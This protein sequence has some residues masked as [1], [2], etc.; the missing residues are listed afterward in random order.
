MSN[1]TFVMKMLGRG[2]LRPRALL[3]LLTVGWAYRRRDWMKRWPFL[4][5]PPADYIAWRLHTAFG[6][7]ASLPTTR[8]TEAFLRWAR[9]MS[10]R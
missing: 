7:A 5:L 3:L 4:P 10:R 1:A 6:S 8:Q 9:S 2:L